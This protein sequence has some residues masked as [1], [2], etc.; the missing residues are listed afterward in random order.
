MDEI[1]L[2]TIDQLSKH[3]IAAVTTALILGG[4]LHE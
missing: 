2:N 3:K 4:V 1:D